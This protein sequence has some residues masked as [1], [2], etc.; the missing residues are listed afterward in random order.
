MKHEEYK[1][2]TLLDPKDPSMKGE[3]NKG[4]GYAK[5][6]SKF[7]VTDGLVIKPFSF[8]SAVSFLNDSNVKK[9]DLEETIISIGVKEVF[10]NELT[11]RFF[12]LLLII[13]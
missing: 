13:N 12:F 6:N 7:V 2:V 10:I 9:Q 4:G 11:H 3:I 5:E 1:P 8:I